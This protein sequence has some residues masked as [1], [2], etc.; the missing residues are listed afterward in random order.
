MIRVRPSLVAT[1]SYHFSTRPSCNRLRNRPV[2]SVASNSM[3]LFG[4]YFTSNCSQDAFLGRRWNT[5]GLRAW[6]RELGIVRFHLLL[7]SEAPLPLAVIVP[8]P[9]FQPFIA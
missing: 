3:M 9:R 1:L 4:L 7:A 8:H 5:V 2:A 6:S